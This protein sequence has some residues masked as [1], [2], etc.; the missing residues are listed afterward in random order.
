ME[1]EEIIALVSGLGAV[2]VDRASRESGAPEV[3]WGDTFLTYEPEGRASGR[4]FQPFVTVVT[5]D[6]PDFD[7]A[8]ALDREGVF[9][10]NV[11]VGGELFTEV[12]GHSPAEHTRQGADVDFAEMDRLMPHPTYAAQ[13]WVAV[14]CPGPRTTDRLRGLVRSAW[15]R[16]AERHRAQTAG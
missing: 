9:R 13:G 5:K 4:G 16:A 8:S 14:V 3:A 6:Y 10:V 15:E 2:R 12:V 11:A 7:T 1:A